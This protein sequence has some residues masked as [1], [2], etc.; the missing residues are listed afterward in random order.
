M[1]E[2]QRRI[3]MNWFPP[4]GTESKRVVVVFKILHDGSLTHLAIDKSS[5]SALADQAALKA[6]ER[7]QPF[8]RLP[9]GAEDDADIQFTFDY[10]VFGGGRIRQF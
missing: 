3:K 4:S 1:A 5:G 7:A 9:E 6:V 2:L 8:S 10:N